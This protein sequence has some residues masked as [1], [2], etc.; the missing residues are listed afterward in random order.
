MKK[1]IGLLSILLCF[2]GIALAQDFVTFYADCYYRGGAT[3]LYPGRHSLGGTTVGNA[4]VSS[5]R[6]P[7]GFKVVVYDSE[8]PGSGSK[9]SYT[10]DISCLDRDWNNRIRSV[11]IERN[12]NASSGSSNSGYPITIYKDCDYRG[13]SRGLSAGY[14][15]LRDLGI[16]GNNLSSLRLNSGYGVI[17]YDQTDYKGRQDKWTN[18]VACLGDFNDRTMSLYVYKLQGGTS[19]TPPGNGGGYPLTIYMDCNYRGNSKNLSAGY[20]DLR[21]LG[22]GGNNLSSL[23]LSDGY[24]VTIYDQTGFKGDKVTHYDDVPCLTKFNDRTMSLYVFRKE[25]SS[26][27]NNS[28]E[29]VTFYSDC[30][31]SGRRSTLQAGAYTLRQMGISDNSISSIRVPRGY[32]ILVFINDNFGGSMKNFT[33]DVNCLDNSWNDKISSVQISKND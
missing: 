4:N 3:K 28:G 27:G 22:I 5:I 18:S 33:S 20:H 17:L 26:S 10:A 9:T 2:S 15:N 24:A 21:D 6:I 8:E 16:G 12:S 30:N 19:P 23:R 32:S 29:G 14:H 25:N 7:S 11:V 31:Y 1:G 13:D